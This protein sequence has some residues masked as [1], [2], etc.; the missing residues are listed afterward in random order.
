LT[1]GPDVEEN[2]S[3]AR[4][5]HLVGSLPADD[6]EQ[7]MR[8]ALKAEGPRMHS[9]PDG[10]TGERLNW[11]IHII[12]GLREHPDLDVAK[13]GE[14]ADYDDL[15]RL[16]VRRGHRL[17]GDTLDFG[18]VK[19]FDES[20]PIFTRTREE[21]GHP[22]LA[23]QVGIPGD[24]DMALFTLGPTGPFRYR[25][26]FRA[27][28]LNEIR[29]IHGRAG[30]DVVFQIEVPAELVFV[31]RM[32]GPLQRVMARYL[33]GGIAR[34]VRESPPETRFGIHLCLG[35]MN[36]KA[37]AA[38]RD[39]APVVRLANAIVRAWPDGRRLEYIH[40]PFAAAREPP[41]TDRAWYAPLSRLRLPPGT[42]FIAGFAHEDQEL[43][44]Q[45]KIRSMIDELI[46]QRVDVAT[47]CGLGRRSRP[48]AEAALERIAVL[49][50]E[51]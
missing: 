16:K 34:L 10:E 37:L 38:M 4:A 49:T 15:T 17:S 23:F 18:H 45:L 25:A 29:A 12:E 3:A 19:A 41:R 8:M 44:D 30:S 36:H 1:A 28:T 14:W 26:P 5:A 6:A 11:I 35:D 27:A 31:A 33:A 13:E 7:A 9:L 46:G 48:A 47:A 50:A 24:F 39:A 32:P 21:L 51:E 42:R 22:E 20:Y 40:A 43:A 2:A